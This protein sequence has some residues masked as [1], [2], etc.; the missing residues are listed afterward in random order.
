MLRISTVVP[1]NI[2]PTRWSMGVAV[3]LVSLLV[4]TMCSLTV[5]SCRTKGL[6]CEALV[7]VASMVP[8]SKMLI[9]RLLLPPVIAAALIV[10]PPVKRESSGS[11]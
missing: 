3:L 11:L 4:L 7:I 2:A 5:P 1:G 9:A 6:R 10:P 8:P